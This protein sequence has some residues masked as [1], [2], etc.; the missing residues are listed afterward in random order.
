VNRLENILRSFKGKEKLVL[1]SVALFLIGVVSGYYFFSSNPEFVQS[2][3]QSLL[4]NI[5]R[6][7]DAVKNKSKLHVT[8]LIFQNNVRALI[9][10]LFGG[11]A[12]G[13][14][15]AFGIFFNGMIMGIVMAMAFS[16]GQSPLFF[17]AGILPHGLLELPVLLVA[18][19][20]GLKTGIDLLMPRD[21]R[22]LDLFKENLNNS[23]LALGVF[24]PLLFVA[25]AVEAIITPYVINFLVGKKGLFS[26]L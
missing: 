13:L 18:G 25:A 24:V 26:I 7:S 23:V 15:S 1:V 10:I 14:I 11:I 6:I 8:G 22:G 21:R 16:K 4:G 9:I 20:F 5:M 2:N 3:I 12:F 17:L 19:A